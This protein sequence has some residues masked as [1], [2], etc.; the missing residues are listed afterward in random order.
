MNTCRTLLRSQLRRFSGQR[1]QT[2][3][4]EIEEQLKQ[5]PPFK[6]EK[7]QEFMKKYETSLTEDR[8]K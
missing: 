3:A 1:S 2:A 8:A 6:I 5:L 4:A 7:F